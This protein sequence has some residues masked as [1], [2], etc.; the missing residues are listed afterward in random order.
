MKI[1]AVVPWF[2]SKRTLA[3]TIVEKLGPHVS[4]Y[5]LFCGSLA[6]ELAKPASRAETAVDMHGDATNL[7]WVLQDER[8]AADLYARL[9]RTAPAEGLFRAS[10]ARVKDDW[11]GEAPDVDRAFD[12]FFASWLCRN[13]TAGTTR[14]D[15]N[16]AVRWTANGGSPAARFRSAVE[17]IPDWHARLLNILILRRDVFQVVGRIDDADGTAV[18]ADPPYLLSTRKGDRGGG[19]YRHE[20]TAADHER[21]AAELRRFTR[22]RVVVSYYAD[23]QLAD[24]YPGWTVIDCARAKNLS[25]TG[26]RGGTAQVAPEVLLVNRTA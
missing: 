20:F 23:P 1:K 2:G 9:Q 25:A 5:G 21:L 4:Y 14:P 16:V 17:S 8:L 22:A 3:D 7:A 13:G 24:L 26:S 11:T 15:A 12:Y 10:Q 18:Y 19:R 6:V